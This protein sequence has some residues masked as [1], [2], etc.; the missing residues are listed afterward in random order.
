VLNLDS[1]SRAHAADLLHFIDESPSPWHAV[2]SVRKRLAEY[3]FIELDESQPWNLE[4][5]ARYFVVRDGSSIIAFT[6]GEKKLSETGFR[7]VGA[8]T[9]SPGLRVKPNAWILSE[10]IER[11]GVEVYGS[12]ILATFTD[13]DLSLAGRVALI[14]ERGNLEVRLLKVNKPLLRLP[15]LA[16]H[17]NRQVNEEGLRLHLQNELPLIFACGDTPEQGGNRFLDLLG[18]Q[19]DVG[20]D[21]ITAW[22]LAV[23]DS[24]KGALY[25]ASD[26]FFADSQIDNLASC[27]AA[28]TAMLD[29]EALRQSLTNVCAFF[30]HEEIGSQSQKGADGSFLSDVLERVAFAADPGREFY[31]RALARSFLIS[32]DMA[33]AYQPNFGSAYEPEHPV[34]VNQGPVIKINVN[35]RYSTESISHSQ[36]VRLC[37]EAEVPWQK[38]SHRSDLPC[39]STIGPMTSAKLGIR[40]IDVGCPM[41]A[42]H[43]IRESAGVLDHTYMTRVLK[44]FFG[45]EMKM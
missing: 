26:E 11:I 31:K 12:P 18:Q 23:F 2:E 6:K 34:F 30:D 36:F 1:D 29:R 32:A 24:Q 45:R 9:D 4:A 37:S 20:A 8:H 38:Y 13:R 5:G 33:H 39:G 43:S 14:D 40:S 21:Q 35:Q 3:H 44:R 27:H 22:D 25:G 42:M 19:L 15:N 41:W 7:I 10:K 28:L 16:I 17:M